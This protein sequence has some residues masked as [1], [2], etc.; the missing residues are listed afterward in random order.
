MEFLEIHFLKLNQLNIYLLQLKYLCCSNHVFHCSPCT[1]S[2]N[3]VPSIFLFR[4]KLLALLF[5]LLKILFFNFAYVRELNTCLP[6]S[7]S[8]DIILGEKELKETRDCKSCTQRCNIVEPENSY[9]SH[10]LG[11]SSE[12]YK[13]LYG[14][15]CALCARNVNATL[16]HTRV[17]R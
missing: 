8:T 14:C 11:C 13:L 7:Q 2:E 10:L 9:Q 16:L 12:K 4:M 17:L 1:P 15:R 5:L 6:E 3:V